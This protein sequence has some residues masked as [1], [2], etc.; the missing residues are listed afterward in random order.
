MRLVKW[1]FEL[2]EMPI[3]QRKQAAVTLAGK[4]RYINDDNDDN[5][6]LELQSI[7]APTGIYP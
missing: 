7:G 1:L 5:T 4:R 3:S 2:G 6:E